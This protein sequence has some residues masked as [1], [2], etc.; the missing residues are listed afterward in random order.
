MGRPSDA[1]EKLLQVAF[2]LIWNQSYG[3]V[4]VDHICDRAHV[5]KGSFYHFF[6]SKSDLAVEAYEV[7]WREKQPELDR[8]FS[9]QIPP[10]ERLELWCKHI[11]ERQKQKADKYGHVCGCPYASLGTEVATQDE[12]IRAKSQELMD[13]NLRYVESALRDAQ[14]EGLVSIDPHS[15]AKRIYSTALG[16]LLYA[17]IHNDLK[18][19]EELEPAVMDIVGARE[20]AA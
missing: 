7:H 2:D 11:W 9:P 20:L 3:S 8:I 13:R 17:K 10:L 19:L 15:G 5:N 14:R 18:V 1:K 16:L 4:S 12:K 6:P